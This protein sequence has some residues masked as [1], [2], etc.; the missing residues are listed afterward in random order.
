MREHGLDIIRIS[1]HNN[2]RPLCAPYQ[3]GLFSISN[4]SGFIED[5]F[6][7]RHEYFPLN[8]TTYG[9]P[10]G[11]FGINCG[12]YGTAIRDKAFFP[13][14]EQAT[15]E[16]D[17]EYK[18]ALEERERKWKVRENEVLAEM[19][20]AVG[21]D[22]YAEIYEKKARQAA[23]ELEAWRRV[24]TRGRGSGR[25]GSRHGANELIRISQVDINNDSAVNLEINKF[26]SEFSNSSV[27]YSLD[28]S[29]NGNAYLVRGGDGAVN[30]TELIG[31]E[32]LKGSIGI[33]NHP[34]REGFSIGD[35]FSKWDLYDAA[36]NKKG[37]QELVSGERRNAFEFTEDITIDEIFNAWQMAEAVVGDKAINGYVFDFKQH[38][39]LKELGR[40]LRGF[41][42][43]EN[44]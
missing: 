8:S 28:I 3:G 25:I 10:A 18:Q 43:Y 29:H 2:A 21:D 37:R 39:V 17:A 34:L 19:F 32:A 11:L 26:I 35:S 27:E 42:Y 16:D 7:E 44:I 36:V 4:R 33:H 14:N 24:L 20:K 13:N 1:R 5:I 15:D 6:G 22:E 23:A 9:E 40:F 41:V 12:H 30:S 38:E 31:S